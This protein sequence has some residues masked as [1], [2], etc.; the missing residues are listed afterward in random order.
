MFAKSEESEAVQ[1]ELA[2]VLGVFGAGVSEAIRTSVMQQMDEICMPCRETNFLSLQ[3]GNNSP[4]S[5]MPIFF[6]LFTMHEGDVPNFR[7]E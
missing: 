6:R 3:V 7:N 4:A 5:F 1:E 2:N